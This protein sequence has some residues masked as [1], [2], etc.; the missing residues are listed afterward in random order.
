MLTRSLPEV[1]IMGIWG[2]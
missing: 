2:A 1:D